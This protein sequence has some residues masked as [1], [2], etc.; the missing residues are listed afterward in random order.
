MRAHLAAGQRGA[1]LVPFGVPIG[2]TSTSR[3]WR[4]ASLAVLRNVHAAAQLQ[5]RKGATIAAHRMR[6]AGAL[7][8]DLAAKPQP[9]AD[10][11]QAKFEWCPGLFKGP[12]A[13]V[14]H[15]LANKLVCRGTIRP[16]IA[17]S[18]RRCRDSGVSATSLAGGAPRR[19]GLLDTAL[20]RR[21]P[22]NLR[23]A[24]RADWPGASKP[25]SSLQSSAQC[26]SGG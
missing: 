23:L 7:C 8:G 5:V 18:A 15:L 10:S 9:R 6:S 20:A 1:W 2:L 21:R 13:A 17:S 11:A 14:L 12:L 4:P 24:D 25:A 3:R 19:P 16:L 26:G 22:P